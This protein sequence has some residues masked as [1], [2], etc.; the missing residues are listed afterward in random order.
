MLREEGFIQMLRGGG[1]IQSR[2]HI[3]STIAFQPSPTEHPAFNDLVR[4][5]SNTYDL[6]NCDMHNIAHAATVTLFY[7]LSII[8]CI[9]PASNYGLLP[10]YLFKILGVLLFPQTR[11][12]ASTYQDCAVFICILQPITQSRTFRF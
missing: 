5:H 7:Y 8:S 4:R 11:L 2:I 3:R 10:I 9:V 1:L 12:S 6:P